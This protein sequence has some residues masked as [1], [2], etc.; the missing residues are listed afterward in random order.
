MGKWL[1]LGLVGCWNFLWLF[2]FF[3][4]YVATLHAGEKAS[5]MVSE[6]KSFCY[7]S[8]MSDIYG[9]LNVPSTKKAQKILGYSQ[10][11]IR[12]IEQCQN[13]AIGTTGNAQD[14]A[15]QCGCAC[16]KHK[17][18]CVYKKFCGP[19]EGGIL[20]RANADNIRQLIPSNEGD[21]S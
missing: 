17:V 8:D 12:C 19:R 16:L 4:L 14:Q 15:K 7:P 18:P 10:R 1:R 20:D 21:I 6:K 2:S 9:P 5:K 3:S 13:Q 11:V